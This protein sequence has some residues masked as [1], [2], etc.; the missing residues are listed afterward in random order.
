MFKVE[1]NIKHETLNTKPI[2]SRLPLD[3]ADGLRCVL[4]YHIL[5]LSRQWH[6]SNIKNSST[7]V[8]TLAT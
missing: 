5:L 8:C 4:F 7:L 1:N 6:K 3:D 2:K